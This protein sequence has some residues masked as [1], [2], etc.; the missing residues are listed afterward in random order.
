MPAEISQTPAA[1]SGF[2]PPLEVSF[3]RQRKEWESAVPASMTESPA[4]AQQFKNFGDHDLSKVPATPIVADRFLESLHFFQI[5]FPMLRVHAAVPVF[6]IAVIANCELGKLPKVPNKSIGAEQEADAISPIRCQQTHQQKDQPPHSPRFVA[7]VEILLLANGA[8][9]DPVFLT[10]RIAVPQDELFPAARAGKQS[11]VFRRTGPAFVK[12]VAAVKKY[13][14]SAGRQATLSA[15]L[16]LSS[17]ILAQLSLVCR[18][19]L[20]SVTDGR[21]P[22]KTPVPCPGGE[23]MVG[24]CGT[25]P[26]FRG[27]LE[28]FLTT[29]EGAAP[30]S[31]SEARP[32]ASIAD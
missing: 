21:V 30:L 9:I 27:S 29:P 10:V 25:V 7:D 16:R 11:F 14:H 28:L 32:P 24:Q 2:D 12:T 3:R 31:W 22:S 1:V 15:M 17:V 5:V 18:I 4:D 20:S 8:H 23:L 19:A 6:R 13:L 26:R